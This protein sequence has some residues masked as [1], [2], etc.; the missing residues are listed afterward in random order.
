MIAMD[1][2]ENLFESNKRWNHLGIHLISL[3][4]RSNNAVWFLR[5]WNWLET[6]WLTLLFRVRFSS[7][8]L[9]GN[10]IFWGIDNTNYIDLWYSIPLK[11]SIVN[12]NMIIFYKYECVLLNTIKTRARNRGDR[13]G[14]QLPSKHRLSYKM[15]K[16]CILE[17]VSSPEKWK[18]KIFVRT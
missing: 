4:T 17:K 12:L 16:F 7:P 3:S 5:L 9:A 11:T 15:L 18:T 14:R 13:I 10:S 1:Y 8:K 2:I 6:K